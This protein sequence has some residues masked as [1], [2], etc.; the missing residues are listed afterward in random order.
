MTSQEDL[1]G[2]LVL[3]LL[4]GK[5]GADAT[6]FFI[7]SSG[8][9]PRVGF[10]Y[11]VVDV[12]ISYD[13]FDLEIYEEK[14]GLKSRDDIYKAMVYFAEKYPDIKRCEDFD[15]FLEHQLFANEA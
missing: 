15:H 9:S 5:E 10:P 3:D 4:A 12:T 14:T 1:K 11:Y 8:M 2:R 13:A 7:E 6:L